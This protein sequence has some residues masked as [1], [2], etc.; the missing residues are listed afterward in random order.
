MNNT[1][2]VVANAL[3][4]SAAI[5]VFK[6][7]MTL[8]QSLGW[9]S[10]SAEQNSAVANFLDIAIPVIAVWLGVIWTKRNVTSLKL[11]TDVDGAPLTRPDNTPAIK[12]LA[13][14][15][16]EAIEINKEITRGLE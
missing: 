7:F 12:E 5:V 2:P 11:P 16:K 3:S 15:Q 13:V 14:L 9:W 1:D 8:G 10:L 6:A 4:I